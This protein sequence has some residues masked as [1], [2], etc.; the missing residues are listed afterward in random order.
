MQS[1]IVA[2]LVPEGSLRA[3]MLVRR[4]SGQFAFESIDARVAAASRVAARWEASKPEDPS[5]QPPK[6]GAAS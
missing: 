5:G 2:M 3:T 4:A 6:H 1:Q